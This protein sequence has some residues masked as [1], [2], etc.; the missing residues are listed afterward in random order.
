MKTKLDP[1]FILDDHS[2][3]KKGGKLKYTLEVTMVV[4][5]KLTSLIFLEFHDAKVTKCKGAN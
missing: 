2:I 5:K 4:P 3:F 1:N